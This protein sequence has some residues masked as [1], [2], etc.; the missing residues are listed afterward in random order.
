M[1]V[2]D[3]SDT[4]VLFSAGG[5]P[6]RGRPTCSLAGNERVADMFQKAGVDLDRRPVALNVAEGKPA[7]ASFTTTTPA[8]QATAPANAVDGVDDQRPADPAGQLHR[9]QPD[10]GHARLAERGG[11]A[12]GRPR[13]R[14]A[15][16]RG[17]ALL[18]LEQELRRG[19]QHVP[20]A[21]LVRG[22]VPRRVG[23]GR[24]AARE[25]RPAPNYNRVGFPA[26]EARRWRV[27]VTPTT[28]LR[29]RGQGAPALRSG[30]RASSRARWEA[31]CRRRCR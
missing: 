26:V 16:R 9:P 11:L 28:G 2:L 7:T 3:G 15:R 19:W 10:L 4:A 6:G 13:R 23:L 14:A 31:R 21:R 22:A 30:R 29:G 5:G 27:L 20:R 25:S 8:L 18:L 24:A 12:R 17:Q 1:S